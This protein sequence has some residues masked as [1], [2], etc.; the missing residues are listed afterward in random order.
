MFKN[1]NLRHSLYFV[2]LNYIVPSDDLKFVKINYLIIHILNI[3]YIYI[4]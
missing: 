1:I 2:C 3:N 4:I